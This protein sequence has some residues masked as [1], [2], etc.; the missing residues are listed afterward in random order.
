MYTY[1]PCEIG[2]FEICEKIKFLRQENMCPYDILDAQ[3]NSEMQKYRPQNF[4]IEEIIFR[5]IYAPNF[6]KKNLKFSLQKLK[7]Q[8]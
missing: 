5:A 1:V 3:S 2:H 8:V 7:K 4:Q 6:L